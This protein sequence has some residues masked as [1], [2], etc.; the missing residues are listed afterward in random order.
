MNEMKTPKTIAEKIGFAREVKEYKKNP[1][2]FKGHVG[3][4]SNVLRVAITTRTKSPD[5]YSIIKTIGKEKVI[6]RIDK[7]VEE[8]K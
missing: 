7:Y 2:M 3:D 6:S 1:E 8:L 5:L 4:V